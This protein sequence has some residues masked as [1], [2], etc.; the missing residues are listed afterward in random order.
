MY[1][2]E[3]KEKLEL[4]NRVHDLNQVIEEGSKAN[5]AMLE[6]ITQL[7]KA[8]EA[9]DS[10]TTEK[11]FLE[12]VRLKT[13]S[14]ELAKR[15]AKQGEHIVLL[16]DTIKSLAENDMEDESQVH[17]AAEGEG[18]EVA[19]GSTAE[20]DRD[21]VPEAAKVAETDVDVQLLAAQLISL[22]ESGHI[23]TSPQA[24]A[25]PKQKGTVG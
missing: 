12:N 18:A 4:T 13:E 24:A 23:R 2:Q 20:A 3:L 10:T 11:L 14:E 5:K 17:D 25:E 8:F 19:A 1:E 15:V 16:E 9:I 21:K 22:K 6:K 7:N